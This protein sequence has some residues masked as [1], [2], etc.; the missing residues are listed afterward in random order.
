MSMND[1]KEYEKQPCDCTVQFSRSQCGGRGISLFGSSLYHS[2]FITLK[3]HKASVNRHLHKDWIHEKERPLIEVRL[4]PLQ[5]SDLITTMNYTP[6]TPGTLY[7]FNGERY[8]PPKIYN[9]VNQFKQ[10]IEEDVKETLQHLK[11]G[12]KRLDELLNRKK[13]L[14]KSEKE[15]IK[16]IIHIAK[17]LLDDKLPFTLDSFGE[18]MEK[19]VSEAK[20]S[21]NAYVTDTVYKTGIEILKK[22]A[23][24]LIEEDIL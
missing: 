18:Q 14:V 7:Q 3:V 5:F 23:P 13:P 16:D 20:A 10:E 1:E 22:N 24:K 6:G 8:E 19:T 17:Q 11:N 21:I 12:L 4:S 9:K 15:E 2:N